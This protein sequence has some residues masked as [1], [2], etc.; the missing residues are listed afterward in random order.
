MKKSTGRFWQPVVLRACRQASRPRHPQQTPFYQLACP[1]QAKRGRQVEPFFAQS[2]A[3]HEGRYQ[4]RYGFWR[5]VI[6]T[7]VR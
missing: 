5:L 6:G 4:E 2:E 1:R 3:V 7:V